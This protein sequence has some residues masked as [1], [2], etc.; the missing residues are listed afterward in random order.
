M[1][2]SRADERVLALFIFVYFEGKIEKLTNQNEVN[3]FKTI[4]NIPSENI[5]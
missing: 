4:F 5:L 2:I 1:I 3:E